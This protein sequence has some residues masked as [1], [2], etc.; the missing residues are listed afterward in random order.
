MKRYRTTEYA[1]SNSGWTLLA[2]AE[3]MFNLC[4]ERVFNK[5]DGSFL[6]STIRID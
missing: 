2:P 4:K 3:K 6:N 5:N 1:R